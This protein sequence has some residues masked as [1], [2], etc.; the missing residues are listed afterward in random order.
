MKSGDLTHAVNCLDIW[1]I[2]FDI[3]PNSVGPDDTE[4]K[5]IRN[6]GEWSEIYM[7]FSQVPLLDLSLADNVET[8]ERFLEDLKNALLNVGFLYIK[9]Y[10]IDAELSKRVCDLGI[11][12]F[13]LPEDAKLACEMK[14][15]PHFLGYNRLGTEI[16][17]QKQ[18]FREQIDL[19][20]ELP[21]PDLSEPRYR[22]LRGPNFWPDESLLPG[23]R[24]TYET[25]MEQMAHVSTRFLGL[26]A[27]AIGLDAHAF[28]GFFEPEG[29][30]QQHKL[31][32][33]KYPDCK[34][35]PANAGTQGVGPHKDSMLSSFLLQATPH[36]GLQV[37]N[38]KGDWIDC[39][40]IENTLV[41]ALGQ[42]LESITQGVC[43]STTHRVISPPAGHGARYSIPFFQ[44]VGLDARFETMR[45]PQ[46]VRDLRKETVKSDVE[47][48]FT[49]DAGYNCIGEAILYNRVKSHPDGKFHYFSNVY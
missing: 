12:F 20:T 35:L 34:D 2:E 15:G 31:K 40:P 3:T 43:V 18:D 47:F 36:R 38:A 41:V 33:V 5:N 48:T 10:G 13:D 30:T 25:Y 19:A 4:G 11:A 17:A 22:W 28:D 37:Q 1:A 29:V 21:V 27:E 7:D 8:R 44:G 16:T 9:K 32:I 39:P 24:E 23:F 46:H 49:K 26:V 6:T 42:G 14:N 45:I